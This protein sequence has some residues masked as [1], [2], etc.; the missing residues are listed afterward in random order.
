MLAAQRI[1][2]GIV[3]FALA[4][5]QAFAATGNNGGAP[6]NATSSTQPTTQHFNVV[7]A[8]SAP[9]QFVEFNWN[10]GNASAFSVAPSLQGEDKTPLPPAASHYVQVAPAVSTV[11]TGVASA[12]SSRPLTASLTIVPVNLAASSGKVAAGQTVTLSWSGPN[13]G[14]SYFLT[15]LPENSTMPLVADSCAGSICTGKYLTAPLGANRTF[16]VSATGPY[17]GQAWS[18]P[19]AISVTGGMS[20]ACAASPVTPSSGGAATIS[21]SSSN[22]ISVSIDQGIGNVSPPVSGSVTVHPTQTTTYR[23]TATDRFGDHLSSPAKVIV[24]TGDVNNLNHITFLLQENRSFDNYF[25]NLA[26]Y[27]VNIDHIPGAQ[28][29]DVNDLHNLP[30]GFM[31]QN[32]AGQS[33]PPYHQRTECID[34]LNVS[35]NASHTDMDLVG[36][37]WL[38]L[39][40]NSQYLM[41]NFLIMTTPSQYDSTNTRPLGYYDWTD[42]PYYYELATQFDTSDTFYSPVP[43]TTVINRMYLFAATSYGN[44]F[45]PASNNIAWV[46][47]TIFRVLQNAG[48]SWRYYYQDDSIFLSQWADWNNPQIQANVRNIQEWYNILASQNADQD[49][50]QVVFIEHAAATGYDEHP[51][52]NV[53]KGAA[54]V[55]Q[56]LSALLTSNAWPDS[57]FILTYDEGG[58]LFDQQPPILV[59]PPDDWP[60]SPYQ[61]GAY[62]RGLFNVTG[63]RLPVILV[64]PWSKPHFVWHMPTDYTSIL[65]LIESRFALLP[66]TQRDATTGDLTDPANGPFDF[67]S[68]QMLQI[69]PLPTQPTTGTCDY[70]LESY[71]Q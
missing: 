27:R 62:I 55:Q 35:W 16:L 12:G 50:P 68:P 63:F 4:T 59:N 70:S 69:P 3:L 66:L 47:P 14:S 7:P 58:G 32:S 53:Q 33:F 67:S 17:Q 19:V 1:L 15:T 20:L 6:Q 57:A 51:G 21:W 45:P 30:P 23:C 36:G 39:T 37:D 71:P 38:H 9:G 26:Y 64:S 5:S 28:M 11:F 52:N 24:S 41:D 54:R 22:A 61:S 40:N 18:Q 29:S 42:L 2:I 46:K 60:P 34:G 56:I 49:L 65:R 48:I 13:N 44:I 10:V 25:G 31:L 43:D 8:I